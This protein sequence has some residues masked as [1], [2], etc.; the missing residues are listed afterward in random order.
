MFFLKANKLTGKIVK[1]AKK[2]KQKP[3]KH[4]QLQEKN[5]RGFWTLFV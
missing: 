3:Y 5:R 2:K 4:A 1:L